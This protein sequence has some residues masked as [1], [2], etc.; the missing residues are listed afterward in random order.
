MGIILEILLGFW[1]IRAIKSILFWIYLWQLKEYHIGRFIDHFRTFKGKKIFLNKVQGI[2]IILLLLAL[3]GYYFSQ[4]VLYALLVLYVLESLVFLQN[5]L[6]DKLKK[7]KIT[8]KTCLLFLI[9]FLAVTVFA[10]VLYYQDSL[11]R[12]NISILIFDIL[13]PLI[14]SLIVLLIQPFFVIARNGILRKARIKILAHKNLK[15]VA[16]TGSYGKT[17]TKEFLTTI[18]ASRFRVL[19]TPE[20][21]NSEIGIAQTIFGNLNDNHQIFIVEMGSYNKGGIDLLCKIAKPSIGVVTGVNEQ[22]LSTFGSM[23]NLLSAEGGGELVNNLLPDGLLVVN[24]DNKYCLDLYRKSVINKK[25]YSVK[26][27]SGSSDIWA[28]NVKINKES[29]LFKAVLKNKETLNFSVDVLGEHNV[30]NLLGAI[31]VAKELGMSLEEISRSVRNIKAEQA[32]ITLR[33]GA[34]NIDIID[35]SYSS[36]PDG[37][38]ADLNYLNVFEGKKVIV[39]PCLIE[40]GKKSNEIHR[41]IGKKIAKVCGMAIITTKD[42]FEEIKN[43]AVSSGMKQDEIIFCDNP[44]EIFNLITISCKGGD[45][46]LLE[47]RVPNELIKLLSR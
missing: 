45:T 22:H 16:I 28:E 35:S 13:T 4:V 14:I 26:N 34:N 11:R 33:K 36:N 20:H 7:P 24:G 3:I 25:V 29:L 32:G 46:V 6:N 5:I 9:S 19:S 17:S 12:F 21:K 10:A 39:M 1:F 38:I 43:G 47:G 44:S 15:I 27:H 37:V 31:L 18:L 30:E 23:E 40:L 41:L 2:K 8:F 42:K